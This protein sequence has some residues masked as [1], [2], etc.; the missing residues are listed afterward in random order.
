MDILKKI[1][2]I[3]KLCFVGRLDPVAHGLMI[4]LKND[5][6]KFMNKYLSYKK[7]YKFK[8]LFG[9]ETDSRYSRKNYNK[10]FTKY[11]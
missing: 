5:E 9:I 6:C 8:I 1:Y 3:N 4:Y 7:T 10:S 2:S 11:R